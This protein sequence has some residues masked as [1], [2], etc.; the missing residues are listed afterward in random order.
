MEAIRSP[1]AV[2]R[3]LCSV[4]LVGWSLALEPTACKPKSPVMPRLKNKAYNLRHKVLNGFEPWLS[5]VLNSQAQRWWSG[6]ETI[7][8]HEKND[9]FLNSKSTCMQSSN[10]MLATDATLLI[11]LCTNICPKPLQDLSLLQCRVLWTGLCQK[12]WKKPEKKKHYRG[13]E[14]GFPHLE[15]QLTCLSLR[16]GKS[17]LRLATTCLKSAQGAWAILPKQ[18]Q[19]HWQK[20]KEITQHLLDEDRLP[21]SFATNIL[22]VFVQI[23]VQK[24]IRQET[25][26]TSMISIYGYTCMPRSLDATI[27]PK[28]QRPTP[29]AVLLTAPNKWEF[30]RSETKRQVWAVCNSSAVRLS[31]SSWQNMGHL[32]LSTFTAFQKIEYPNVI[33]EYHDLKFLCSMSV[34]SSEQVQTAGKDLQRLGATWSLY[35]STG[36]WIGPSGATQNVWSQNAHHAIWAKYVFFRMDFTG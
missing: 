11:A 33:L 19:S 29:K 25:Q 22:F 20:W 1:H 17:P 2:A 16:H 5:P 35:S 14:C 6:R 21:I 13:S 23:F 32:A 15:T 31:V 7:I 34:A 27:F 8:Q 9:G 24:S 28:G 30:L 36:Y 3:A 26:S 12:T 4:P 18:N 10:K